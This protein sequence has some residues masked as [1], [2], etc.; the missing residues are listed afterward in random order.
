MKLGKLEL[1]LLAVAVA[2]VF[3]T[4][5]YFSGR[6]RAGDVNVTVSPRLSSPAPEG[7][8]EVRI[9]LNTATRWELMSLPGVGETYADRI[10]AYREEHGGFDTVEEL[11]E[12]RGIG[13]SLFENVKDYLTV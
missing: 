7:A 8:G 4:A 3:F 11:M 6:G 1:F 10:I 12:V 9:D 2:A 5:G 13:K